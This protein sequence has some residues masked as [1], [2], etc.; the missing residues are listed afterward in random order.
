MAE[1]TTDALRVSR[2][3]IRVLMAL[4]LGM[5]VFIVV[6]GTAS[7]VAEGP[8]MRALGV[9]VT[10][11]AIMHGMQ[12]I[13]VLG[14]ASVPLTHGLLAHLR[15]IVDTVRSGDPF[16]PKNA[17]RLQS[18]AWIS[19]GLEVL[20]LLIGAAAGA[21]SSHGQKLDIGWDL[22]PTRWLAIVL[23]FVLARVFEEGTRMREDLEGTV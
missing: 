3:L 4:N 10:N 8:V 18:I 21:A 14:L 17:L 11:R 23:I 6:L 1:R 7:L 19:L 15:A 22:S 16:V 20:H 9:S 12:M 5:G 2:L 13:M